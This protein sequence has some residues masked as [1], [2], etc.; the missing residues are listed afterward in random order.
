M[1]SPHRFGF[2][3][4]GL[5]ALVTISGCAHHEAKSESAAAPSVN[6]APTAPPIIPVQD[7]RAVGELKRMSD[8]LVAARSMTFETSSLTPFHGPNGQWVHVLKTARVEMRRPDKL[9]IVTGGDAVPQRIVFDGKKYSVSALDRQLYSQTEMAGTIDEM[10]AQASRQGGNV[11]TFADVLLSDPY[12]NWIK[13]L[14]GA[15]YVGETDR[16]GE[17]LNHLAFTEKDEDWEVYNSEKDHLPRL[18]YVKY[19]GVK[20]S[21]AILIEFGKWKIN[22]S[23]AAAEFGFQAP[24]GAKK[25]A[26]KAPAG[27]TP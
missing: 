21:P 20:R 18:V 11:L 1:R 13:G 9:S 14:E 3:A 27:G 2:A 16:N 25:A 5:A 6:A 8:A 12:A 24:A 7:Q 15:V 19:L 22:P 23:I 26:L 10:L 17:K 4:L